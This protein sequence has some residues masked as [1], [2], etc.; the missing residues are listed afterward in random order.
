[1][2]RTLALR[3]AGGAI[4]G[5][6]AMTCLTVPAQGQTGAPVPLS[7]AGTLIGW[8]TAAS[9]ADEGAPVAAFTLPADLRDVAFSK[10]V[11]NSDFTVALT[12]AGKVVV[13]NES[14][15][16]NTTIS[17]VP[18]S[19]AAANVIDI[20]SGG[21]WAGA[22]TSTGNVVVWGQERDDNPDPTDVPAGLTDVA[23]LAIASDGSAAAA[24]TN[25]DVVMWG[26]TDD[27]VQDGVPANIG[28]GVK[29]IAAGQDHYYALKSDGNVVAWGKNNVGQTALPATVTSGGHVTDVESGY[30]TGL[31]RLDDG[32]LAYW[33][34][35]AVAPEGEVFPELPL[36]TSLADKEVVKIA[37]AGY[38][39]VAVDDSGAITTWASNSQVAAELGS[40][41]PASLTGADIVGLS[42]GEKYLIAL[43]TKVREA[44]KASVAG[45]PT[46][47]Q[48]LTG[49]PATFSGAPDAITNQWLAG[50]VAIAGATGTTLPLTAAYVGKQITFASTATKA[51]GES[52][53]S[54]SSPTGPVQPVGSQS[55]VPPKPV[56]SKVTF[57]ANKASTSK[58]KG[59]ATVTVAAASGRAKATGKATV[60]IKKGKTT[61]KIKVTLSGGKKS[62]SLPKLKK[63]TWKVQVSYNGDKNY[64]AGKSKSYNL[65]IK[66]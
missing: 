4:A 55:P 26:V 17:Q 8:G 47:G 23:R 2:V 25:G 28:T 58:K 20:V 18:A 49:T 38:N 45:T 35:R 37:A 12:A 31:A 34:H 54:T 44:T 57:K 19:L 16:P 7:E 63:G 62:I 59:K 51:G 27:N 60:T 41:V 48:T 29:A 50:G 3:G 21:T 24:K 13:L 52:S 33:G 10:V 30:N 40:T 36:P 14:G 46:V 5:L 22:I 43:V 1:M 42:W 53:I 6:V 9:G 11:A 64:L 66:K 15:A 61:K 32:S 65:K 56:K 39:F